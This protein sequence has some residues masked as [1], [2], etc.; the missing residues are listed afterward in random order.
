[1]L[2]SGDIRENDSGRSA[3]DGSSTTEATRN[4]LEESGSSGVDESSGSTDDQVALVSAED[5]Q[6][7]S[8]KVDALVTENVLLIFALF[9]VCGILAVRTFVRSFEVF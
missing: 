2:T 3:D 9:M 1:M 5:F 4:D 7:L 6:A 8:T